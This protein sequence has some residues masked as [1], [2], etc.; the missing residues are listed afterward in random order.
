MVREVF[1]MSCL[2]MLAVQVSQ[3]FCARGQDCSPV[4]LGCS[5]GTYVTKYITWDSLTDAA[6]SPLLPTQE[7]TNLFVRFNLALY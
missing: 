1:D 7:Q 4:G 5:G 2:L 3:N 6:L